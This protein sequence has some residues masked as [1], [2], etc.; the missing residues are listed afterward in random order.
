MAD[1]LCSC[2]LKPLKLFSG[3]C[4]KMFGCQHCNIFGIE[5]SWKDARV[6]FYEAA[7]FHAGKVGISRSYRD[8]DTPGYI[9]RVINQVE[10]LRDGKPTEA[11][12]EAVTVSWR[13]VPRG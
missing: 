7:H 2:G 10:A 12:Q 6:S 5:P 13:E 3:P 9:E 1:K 4:W 11:K 8:A